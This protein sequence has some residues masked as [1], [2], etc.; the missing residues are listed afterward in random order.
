MTEPAPIEQKLKH[1]ILRDELA[2]IRTRLANRRTLMAAG[3]TALAL[4]GLGAALIRFFGHPAYQVLGWLCLA[5]G[6]AVM[7]FGVVDYRR[8]KREMDLDEQN[9][10]G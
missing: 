4:A 8:T 7:F 2:E 9:F 5:G 1:L 3:R 6:T 10:Q